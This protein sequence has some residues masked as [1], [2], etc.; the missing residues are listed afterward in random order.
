MWFNKEPGQPPMAEEL[1]G[2]VAT[3]LGDDT[4][5]WVRLPGQLGGF[6]TRVIAAGVGPC[7][8]GQDHQVKHLGL[9]HDDICVA[10]CPTRGF[11]WYRFRREG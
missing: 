5:D 1:D 11:L 10:E 8:C 4:P 3:L 2:S 9:E 7:V 6:Q